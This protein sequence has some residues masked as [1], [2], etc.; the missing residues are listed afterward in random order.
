MYTPSDEEQISTNFI[1][2]LE[3]ELHKRR[4]QQPQPHDRKYKLMLKLIET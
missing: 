2:N 3:E 1:K 4:R